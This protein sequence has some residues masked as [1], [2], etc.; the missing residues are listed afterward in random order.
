MDLKHR[1]LWKACNEIRLTAKEFNLLSFLMK[2]Q[3]VPLTHVELLHRVWGQ[4]RGSQ[5]EYLRTY[6]RRLRTKIEDTPANPKFLL[7]EPR[8]GYRFRSHAPAPHGNPPR[9]RHLRVAVS[10]SGDRR[11]PLEGTRRTLEQLRAAI[12][13]GEVVFPSPAPRFRCQCR[14]EIQWRVAELYLIHGWTCSRLAARYGVTRGRIWWF[15]RS[16]IDRA[17]ALGYLQDIPPADTMIA[18]TSHADVSHRRP[19]E[20]P[21]RGQ[22]DPDSHHLPMAMAGPVWRSPN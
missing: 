12:Q 10:I 4:H 22:P 14:P 18:A 13:K 2:N 17:L 1:S 5:R 16:W 21:A 20:P 9:Q 19:V 3:D 6:V 15:V 11:T 8:V 7:T